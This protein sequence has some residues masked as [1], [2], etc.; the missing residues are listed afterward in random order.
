MSTDYNYS[1]NYLSNFCSL[2]SSKNVTQNKNCRKIYNILVVDDDLMIAESLKT[3]LNHRG[4]SVAVVTDGISCISH[5]KNEENK[6]DLIFLDYHMDGLDGAQVAEIVKSDGRKTLIF[7][8][9]GDNS[10][11]AIFEFKKVGI[12][13]VVVKPI[14]ISGIDMLMSK[15]ENSTLLT[16]STIATLAR[17]SDRS[18][19]IF[20]ELL[21]K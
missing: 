21:L 20:D 7:A 16:K 17:K 9:T 3:L 5:C 6:Y 1:Q 18:I 2:N 10:D 11:T 14:N 12:D 8:Y 19:M 4:H 15:L 13:G